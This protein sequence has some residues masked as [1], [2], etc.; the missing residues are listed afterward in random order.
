M[1]LLQQ[2]NRERTERREILR[3]DVRR[4][5]RNTLRRLAPADK[6]VVFGSLTKPN[7]FTDVSD[8][9]LALEAEPQ[10]MSLYQLTAL[11]AEQMERPVDI[12]LLS[13]CRFRERIARE[14]EVWTLAA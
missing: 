7:R 14:G 4:R 9:D 13:E 8:I 11:L 12:V 2:M 3:L 5:L 1:T 10:G 6:V